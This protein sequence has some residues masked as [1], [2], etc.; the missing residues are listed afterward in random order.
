[1][2]HDDDR[3]AVLFDV[4]GTLV[5][6]NWFHT[7]SWW[8]AFRKKGEFIPM[9]RIH[10]LIGM[11]SDQLVEHLFGE[12]RPEFKGVHGE[13]YEVFLDEI[14][15]FPE[16]A[17]LLREVKRRGAQVVLCTSSQQAHL[18]PML[19]AI[20]AEDAIDDVVNA[21]DVEQSKPAPD[22]FSAGLDKLGLDPTR[23]IVVGDTTWDI[24]AASKLDLSTV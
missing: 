14:V 23:S 22:V 12:E 10:P 3:V 19:E 17:A 6:T 21:D 8:R 4:D 20:D 9:S 11:G 18:G 15:A 7:L 1:M 2:P 5:D 24:D 16:A 13:E